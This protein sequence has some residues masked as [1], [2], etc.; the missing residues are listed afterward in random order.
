MADYE[1]DIPFPDNQKEILLEIVR[2]AR[3]HKI[4]SI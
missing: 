2:R 3:K 4:L 1:Y